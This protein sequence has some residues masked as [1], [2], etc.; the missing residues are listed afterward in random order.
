MMEGFPGG[1]PSLW[2]MIGE[3][4]EQDPTWRLSPVLP[5][6]TSVSLP[7]RAMRSGDVHQLGLR[8]VED[9]LIL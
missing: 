5:E 8:R 1:H 2:R 4:G 6:T 7:G 3:G 9:L